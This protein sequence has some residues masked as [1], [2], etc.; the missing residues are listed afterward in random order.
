MRLFDERNEAK[1]VQKH[2]KRRAKLENKRLLRTSRHNVGRDEVAEEASTTALALLVQLEHQSL[3][4][5]FVQSSRPYKPS[6]RLLLP[7]R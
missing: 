3:E 1:S 7:I 5:H 4:R 2:R 6:N